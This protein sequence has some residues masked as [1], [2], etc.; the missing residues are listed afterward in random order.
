MLILI[1]SIT[2]TTA[3]LL[4][5][6]W[7]VLAVVTILN[8]L[9]TPEHILSAGIKALWIVIIILIPIVGPLAYLLWKKYRK[10]G[11]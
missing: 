2:G 6:L 1:P 8:I 11:V 10:P 4:R 5:A 7:L 9:R 3:F